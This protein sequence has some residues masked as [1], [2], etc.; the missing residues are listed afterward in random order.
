MSCILV[1]RGL[2][3]W[4][5]SV[6][7]SGWLNVTTRLPHSLSI[8]HPGCARCEPRAWGTPKLWPVLKEAVVQKERRTGRF[9]SHEGAREATT[10]PEVITVSQGLDMRSV[11]F[12]WGWLGMGRRGRRSFLT[13]LFYCSNLK[14]IPHV[15]GM[16]EGPGPSPSVCRPFPQSAG[17]DRISAPGEQ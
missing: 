12:L 16:T 10:A 17:A 11:V 5:V 3:R 4:T 1:P 14:A 8:Q 6:L 15:V 2:S 9:R 7:N 13:E